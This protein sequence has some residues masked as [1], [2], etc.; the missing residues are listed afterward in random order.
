MRN[1]VTFLIVVETNIDDYPEDR[2][3]EI[4]KGQFYHETDSY[5]TGAELRNSVLDAVNKVANTVYE[6]WGAV[7]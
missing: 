7:R 4:Y 5:M 1:Q 2:G 3:T 6:S